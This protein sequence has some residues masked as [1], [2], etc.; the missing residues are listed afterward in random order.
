MP[1]VDGV[2]RNMQCWQRAHWGE[3]T[4]DRQQREMCR[5]VRR[6][7]RVRCASGRRPLAE[8]L[9]A[10]RVT[11]QACGSLRRVWMLVQWSRGQ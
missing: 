4:F 7:S 8:R 5:S 11:E 10:P 2:M 3:A 9:D 6:A 1:Q